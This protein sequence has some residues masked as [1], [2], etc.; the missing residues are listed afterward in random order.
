MIL[1]IIPEGGI[2]FLCQVVVFISGAETKSFKERV[3]EI[4]SGLMLVVYI[5]LVFFN[6]FAESVNQ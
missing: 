1:L 6:V 4:N 3:N 5:P 2:I